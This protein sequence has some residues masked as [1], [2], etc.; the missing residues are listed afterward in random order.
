MSAGGGIEGIFS[1]EA[2]FGTEYTESVTSSQSLDYSVEKGQKVDS[3]PSFELTN[4]VNNSGQGYVAGYTL[5]TKFSGK[6]TDC[7]SGE[8]EQAGVVVVP[9]KGSIVYQLVYVSK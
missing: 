4:F 2:T 9:K 7:D 1:I 8:K 5:A 3:L 6:Y